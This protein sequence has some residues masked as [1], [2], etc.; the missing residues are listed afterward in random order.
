MA[1]INIITINMTSLIK[2][3]RRAELDQLAKDKN[4]DIILIQETHLKDRHSLRMSNIKVM[5]NDEGSGT[6]ICIKE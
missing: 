3:E 1:A 4:T 2:R 6:A 5:R